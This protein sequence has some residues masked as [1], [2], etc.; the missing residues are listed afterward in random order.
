MLNKLPLG[1]R[2]LR[3]RRMEP[4][5]TFH[6]KQVAEYVGPIREPFTLIIRALQRYGM[7]AAVFAVRIV[8]R[9]YMP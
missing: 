2:Q 9:R 4:L 6:P 7:A 1:R 3:Q 5:V 8:L